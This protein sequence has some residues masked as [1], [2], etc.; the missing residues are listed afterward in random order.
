MNVDTHATPQRWWHDVRWIAAFLSGGVV[1]TLLWG[2]FG[3]EP[4]I[5]V[6]RETTVLPAPLRA[7]GLPD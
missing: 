6:S 3:P 5:V 7:D 1:G 4:R 2:L